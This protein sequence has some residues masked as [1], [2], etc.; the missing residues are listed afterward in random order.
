[1]LSI[2]NANTINDWFYL[3]PAVIVVDCIVLFLAKYPGQDPYFQVRS[4]NEWYSRFGMVAVISDVMSIL[5]GIMVARY[6]YTYL[7]L[8]GMLSFLAV[9]VAFQLFHDIFFY[10]FVIL[11]LPTGHNQMIDVFK[12]YSQENGFKILFA[13]MAMM[14]SSVLLGSFFKS[15]PTHYTVSS[16]FLTLYALSYILYTE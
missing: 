9:L 3:I 7:K 14:I 11:P 2:A 16:L 10:L 12:K 8:D 15:I 1:M 6:I 4:L 5:I 13:D